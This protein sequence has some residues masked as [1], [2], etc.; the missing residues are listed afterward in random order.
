MRRR[1][2]DMLDSLNCFWMLWVDD[3]FV[4]DIMNVVLVNFVWRNFEGVFGLM[5]DDNLLFLVFVLVV[6]GFGFVV[7]FI[8]FLS[9][10]GMDLLN[11]RRRIIFISEFGVCENINDF[12]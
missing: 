12:M 4:F 9:V 2:V 6:L 3:N 5:V 11:N 7:S 10:L 1:D 8:F